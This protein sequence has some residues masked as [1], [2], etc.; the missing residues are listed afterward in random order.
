MLV[1][2]VVQTCHVGDWCGTDAQMGFG[3]FAW[4]FLGLKV[5]LLHMMKLHVL[6]L[7]Q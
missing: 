4:G 3:T 5:Q 2:A 6:L 1:V 7:V